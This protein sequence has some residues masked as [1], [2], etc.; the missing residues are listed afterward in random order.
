MRDLED[1]YDLDL[2]KHSLPRDRLR[3]DPY[4][5]LESVSRERHPVEV[6]Q[7]QDAVRA[8]E[9]RLHWL[10]QVYGTHL[11]LRLLL[12]EQIMRK[13]YRPGGF[14]ASSLGLEVLS[15]SIETLEPSEYLNQPELSEFLD[16]RAYD[17]H[18]PME[19]RYGLNLD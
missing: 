16:A 15:G 18:A 4:E 19:R 8:S 13:I 3:K 10:A 2:T 7:Q 9:D 5:T 12:E 1:F 14:S 17:V 11:P 6:L